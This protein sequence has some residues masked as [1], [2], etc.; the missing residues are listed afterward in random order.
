MNTAWPWSGLG[1]ALI[2]AASLH[3]VA[4]AVVSSGFEA[5]S[6]RLSAP[7][8]EDKPRLTIELRPVLATTPVATPTADV[9][10]DSS[11]EPLISSDVAAVDPASASIGPP[12]PLAEPDTT[13]GP[14]YF[15]VSEVDKPAVPRPDWQVDVPLLMGLGVRSFSVDV[16]ISETGSAEQCAVTRIEPEQSVDL[17]HVVETKFCETVLSPALRRGVAVR[18]IRHIELLLA[19][20]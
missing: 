13:E 5:P 9:P 3:V 12:L 18:S 6:T 2:G 4:A 11:G 19:P 20:P 1:A 16:L 17:R 7:R 14:R 10:A 15:T 8:T